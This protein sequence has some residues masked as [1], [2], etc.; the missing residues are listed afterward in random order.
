MSGDAPTQLA[1]YAARPIR[2]L[3]HAHV[4]RTT[5]K[6]YGIG[7]TSA[8][9][10][11]HVLQAALAQVEQHLAVPRAGRTIAG[12]DWMRLSESDVGSL[13]VHTGREAVFILLDLWVDQNMLRHH[14]WVAPL[15]TPTAFEP[16]EGTGIT[17]CVWE[18]AVLQHERAA[19]LA[20]V[21]KRSAGPDVASY[22][23]D[24]LNADV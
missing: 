2:F 9:P 21:M 11:A 4:G 14:V 16:L 3:R 18:M 23:A 10:D 5:L 19:W 15:L 7:V 24:V 20:H 12:V 22:L 17:M 6:V 1:P 13:I 8:V